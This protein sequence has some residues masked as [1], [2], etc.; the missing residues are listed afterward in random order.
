MKP[1]RRPQEM[2]REVQMKEISLKERSTK[3]TTLTSAVK[4][5]E[6]N[7]T[8]RDEPSSVGRDINLKLRMILP[9]LHWP[10]FKNSVSFKEKDEAVTVC[11]QLLAQTDPNFFKSDRAQEK[12]TNGVWICMQQGKEP[13]FLAKEIAESKETLKKN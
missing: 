12:T 3:R 7:F 4:S 6:E 8:L 9:V 10:P 2:D 11:E 5:E 1:I 13:S